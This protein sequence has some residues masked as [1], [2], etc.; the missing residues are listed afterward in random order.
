MALI[1]I[2]TSSNWHV[3][4][5]NQH[6]YNLKPKTQSEGKNSIRPI[7]TIS[8]CIF[9]FSGWNKEKKCEIPNVCHDLQ[10]TSSCSCERRGFL[11][12]PC[13]TQKPFGKSE[14]IWKMA[15]IN[16]KQSSYWVIIQIPTTSTFIFY[17][18]LIS[19]DINTINFGKMERF[20]EYQYSCSITITNTK[21]KSIESKVA[22][23][24]WLQ[25]I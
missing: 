10:V 16:N 7:S 17:N 9:G 8:E 5:R 19:T 11:I 12:A 4:W 20:C 13:K 23:T 25:S 24:H 1:S 2:F 21:I 6:T 3:F 22:I 14:R 18:I 15:L